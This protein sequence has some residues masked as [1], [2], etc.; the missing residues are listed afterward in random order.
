MATSAALGDYQV[1]DLNDEINKLL[2][3]KG[4]WEARIRE[5]GGPDYFVRQKIAGPGDSHGARSAHV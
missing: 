1:R 5:L 3:E 2:R 4:H